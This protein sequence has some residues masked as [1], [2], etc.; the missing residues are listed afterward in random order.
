MSKREIWALQSMQAAPLSVKIKLT[1]IRIREW[2]YEY[3]EDGV[4]VSFSGGKDST[5]LLHIVR[6]EF[7]NI[8][9]VF[10]DT[11]LEYPEIRDF[12][13][14]FDNVEWLKPEMNFKQV[15]K[16]YGYPVVSKDVAQCVFD[17]STQ[18]K[19]NNC[20]KRKTKMWQRGFNPDSEY[21]KKYP[22]YSRARYDFLIDAEFPISHR[23]CDIIKKR[24]AKG[25][26]KKTGKK[27]ILATMA[28]ESRL[29]TTQWLADGCNAF[30]VKR[31]TSKPMSFW[32]EQDVL[33]YIKEN[34]L[35]IASVYG[36]IIEDT[37]I[38]GQMNFNDLGIDG[39]EMPKL[40]TT[41]CNRTGCMF[42]L[43]GC[44]SPNYDT[45]TRMKHTHPKQYQWIMKPWDEGGLGYKEVIDW[46]NDH[47]DL[48]IRY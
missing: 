40:K 33:A 14:T 18:A 2:V 46:M 32:T 44:T 9:A 10:V 17:V 29:R 20:D 36:D 19:K 35:P 26:E 42:C 38:D 47:G 5:A 39:F 23:C 1:K 3:G 27:P 7:P 31:P 15:I 25:Y 48:H 34:N 12:V 16:Q 24:P 21:A 28:C 37:E 4:Y 45:F 13:K 11:G 30:D 43:F 22:S 8:P 41:G 6:E